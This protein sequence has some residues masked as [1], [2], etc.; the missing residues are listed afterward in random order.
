ME[1]LPY[2][3]EELIKE[4][5]REYPLCNPSVTASIETIQRRAG[6]R[7]VVD[8]LLVLLARQKEEAQQR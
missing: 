3:S 2:T 6:R 5:D 7:D 1:D 8:K 4:L